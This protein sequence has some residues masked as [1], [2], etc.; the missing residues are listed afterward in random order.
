MS[1]IITGSNRQELESGLFVNHSFSAKPVEGR[2]PDFYEKVKRHV[3]I[4]SGP[5][6]VIDPHATAEIFSGNA[7]SI[8]IRLPSGIQNADTFAF[9]ITSQISVG[10]KNICFVPILTLLTNSRITSSSVE[11]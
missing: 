3:L 7:L 5:A 9:L 1:E 4:L 8:K 10:R 11:L 6:K 2:Y